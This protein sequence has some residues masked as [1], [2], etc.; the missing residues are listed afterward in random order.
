MTI[1]T[2]LKTKITRGN[3]DKADL[4]KKMDVFLLCDRIT[5]EQYEELVKLMEG[6]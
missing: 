6:E 5:A 1:Y 3:Y 2:M 4:L